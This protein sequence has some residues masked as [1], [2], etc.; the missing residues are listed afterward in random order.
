[1]SPPSAAAACAPVLIESG[2]A[3]AI[4]LP[5]TR[6]T[7]RRLHS[8]RQCCPATRAQHTGHGGAGTNLSGWELDACCAH[9]RTQAWGTLGLSLALAAAGLVLVLGVKVHDRT[10]PCCWTPAWI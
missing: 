9:R 7:G 10:R 5:A 1:M 3:D 8:R 4:L 2:T 6:D